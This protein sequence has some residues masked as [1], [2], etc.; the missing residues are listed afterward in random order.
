M[1][2]MQWLAA[3]IHKP[4]PPVP[5]AVHPNDLDEDQ[6]IADVQEKIDEARGVLI[7]HEQFRREQS[8]HHP[9]RRIQDRRR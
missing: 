7:R 3:L 1:S 4:H 8:R 2:L 9:D 5:V 6:L